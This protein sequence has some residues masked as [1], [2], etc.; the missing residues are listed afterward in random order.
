MGS[1]SYLPRTVKGGVRPSFK[2]RVRGRSGTISKAALLGSA[3]PG[4]P[5]EPG[6]VVAGGTKKFGKTI[7]LSCFL[8]KK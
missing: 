1:G 6:E 3:P 2:N 5:G 8:H 4:E 7:E